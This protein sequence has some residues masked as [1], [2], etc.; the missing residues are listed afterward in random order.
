MPIWG[1][2]GTPNL[3]SGK[4]LRKNLNGSNARHASNRE[5]TRIYNQS[6]S[7][8][9]GKP[10]TPPTFFGGKRNRKKE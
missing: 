2:P 5:A 7:S 6:L 4:T 10:V 9:G 3:N 8:A 1:K